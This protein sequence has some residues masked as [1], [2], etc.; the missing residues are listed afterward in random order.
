MD[1]LKNLINNLKR[2]NQAGFSLFDKELGIAIL[3]AKPAIDSVK[4]KKTQFNSKMAIKVANDIAEKE[5]K[6]TA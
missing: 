6:Q 5:S 3:K 1:A 4:G 2:L